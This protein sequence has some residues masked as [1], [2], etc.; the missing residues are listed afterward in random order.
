MSTIDTKLLVS[1]TK[2]L[3]KVAKNAKHRE[4][5]A[6]IVATVKEDEIQ[7]HA[8]DGHRL[9]VFYLR[10]LRSLSPRVL[11]IPVEALA[12]VYATLKAQKELSAEG[13]LAVLGPHDREEHSAPP[14][15]SVIPSKVLDA[16]PSPAA[17][18]ASPTY[19]AQLGSAAAVIP[20]KQPKARVQSSEDMAMIRVDS[21]SDCT[22]FA[23]LGVLAPMRD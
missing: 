17:F 22:E 3:A 21:V 6:C 4:H 12:Q 14:A 13:F 11:E 8:T 10:H 5:L 1:M 18:F 7:L 19:M 23:F 16:A 9:H 20:K 15:P 2:E